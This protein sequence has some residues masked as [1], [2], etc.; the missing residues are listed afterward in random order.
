MSTTTNK[1]GYL[2]SLMCNL[3]LCLAREI[4]TYGIERDVESGEAGEYGSQVAVT[5]DILY[6]I[7]NAIES[8]EPLPEYAWR[9]FPDRIPL[10]L[11]FCGPVV[12]LCF[13]R[14]SPASAKSHLFSFH[15]EFSYWADTDTPRALTVAESMDLVY[16]AKDAVRLCAALA[17]CK[18][19]A[20]FTCP[21]DPW[22][23]TRPQP[24]KPRKS[25]SKKAAKPS[26]TVH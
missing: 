19:A 2:A 21:I 12:W 13:E 24:R 1:S 6:E 15:V 23:L 10:Y 11:H 18:N 20:L 26:T 17:S 8:G 22:A 16:R 25:R 14:I 3:G 7:G 5:A 4:G 9:V